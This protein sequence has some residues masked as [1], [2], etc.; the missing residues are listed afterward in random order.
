VDLGL[1]VTHE[2]LD[3]ELIIACE[4]LARDMPE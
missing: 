1:T 4:S 2:E 3:H